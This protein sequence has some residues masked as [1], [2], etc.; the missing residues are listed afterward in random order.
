M[1][2]FLKRLI[3]VEEDQIREDE[4]FKKNLNGFD[5]RQEKLDGLEDQLSEILAGVE[6]KQRIICTRPGSAASGRYA[7]NL[8]TGGTGG[9]QGT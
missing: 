9:R 3:G 6:T 5:D 4:R 7:L 8:Q 2:I 1:I